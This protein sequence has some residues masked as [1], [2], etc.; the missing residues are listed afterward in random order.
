M[1]PDSDEQS[2]RLFYLLKLLN[3]CHR[4]HRLLED[5]DRI[6]LALS[7]GKDSCALLDALVQRRGIERYQVV[8]IHVTPASDMDCDS[9]GYIWAWG[10]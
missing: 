8:A 9:F 1:R 4:E 5:G 6:A 2:I 7:G 10:K 3:K